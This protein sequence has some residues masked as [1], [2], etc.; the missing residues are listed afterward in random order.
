MQTAAVAVGN[1][2]I[3][4]CQQAVLKAY[5]NL[6]NAYM[7]FRIAVNSPYGYFPVTP[8]NLQ[9]VGTLL[10]KTVLTYPNAS[11]PWNTH[12]PA[13]TTL[14][15]GEIDTGTT[16]GFQIYNAAV[17]PQNLDNLFYF[18]D[19]GKGN[20][21]INRLGLISGLGRDSSN[22]LLITTVSTLSSED[23]QH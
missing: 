21:T 5:V 7:S 8:S 22:N 2:L 9:L 13:M 15:M 17:Q 20:F 23:P 12:Q 14:F 6:E 4:L 11:V 19:A 1:G 16:S 3:S 18:K 10:L